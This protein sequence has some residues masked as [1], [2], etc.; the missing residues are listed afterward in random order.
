M[1]KKK[2]E[3]EKNLLLCKCYQKKGK[4]FFSLSVWE[5]KYL[6]ILQAERELKIKKS[7]YTQSRAFKSFIFTLI[8]IKKFSLCWTSA[9]MYGWKILKR[10]FRLEL[11]ISYALPYSAECVSWIVKLKI[12][13]EGNFIKI[14]INLNKCIR[15]SSKILY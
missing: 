10:I 9:C 11:G 1:R 14:K 5:R 15:T 8:W 13:S 6:W 4:Y 3:R 12:Y 2:A 7:F